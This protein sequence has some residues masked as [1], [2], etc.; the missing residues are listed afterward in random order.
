[1]AKTQFESFRACLNIPNNKV[2]LLS[3]VGKAA[4][5]TSFFYNDETGISGI[6]SVGKNV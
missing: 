5:S 3:S 6:E 1:M 2:A 4:A